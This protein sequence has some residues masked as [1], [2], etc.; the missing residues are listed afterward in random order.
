L[1][2]CWRLEDEFFQRSSES[3]ALLTDEKH[4]FWE[5]NETKPPATKE[6]VVQ[7]MRYA[8]WMF[9]IDS[10]ERRVVAETLCREN[11]DLPTNTKSF[12][13]AEISNQF[14]TVSPN[15]TIVANQKVVAVYN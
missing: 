10:R 2:R 3:E 1:N 12:G 7:K 15:Q 8:R 13:I 11:S 5:F 14:A 4:R 6:T 9:K